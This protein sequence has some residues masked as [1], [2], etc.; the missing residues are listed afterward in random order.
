MFADILRLLHAKQ[1]HDVVAVITGDHT[2]PTAFGD[3]TCE[4]VPIV[5]VDVFNP[6]DNEEQS[7]VFVPKD[8]CHAFDEISAGMDGSLGRF[9]GN[10]LMGLIKRLLLA[11]H[12]C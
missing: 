12:S 6:D 5:F 2:T 11:H 9:Q 3:H 8:D 10:E 1:R 7:S 4:P